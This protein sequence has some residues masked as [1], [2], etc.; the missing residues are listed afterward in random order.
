[1]GQRAGSA[2]ILATLASSLGFGIALLNGTKAYAAPSAPPQRIQANANLLP[3]GTSEN[4]ILTIHLEVREGEWF[5]EDE[6]GPSMKVF[7]LGEPGKPAQIPGPLIRVL[8]GTTIHASVHN[9]L[10][11]AV[12]MH[13]MHSR[14]GKTDDVIDI[15]AGE[16]WHASFSAGE[17]GAYY[18]WA[19]A[20]GDTYL[21]RPYKEDSQL[22]GAF[23]VDPAGTVEHDRIFVIGVWRD[24]QLP[25]KSFDIP[26]INGK[27][28]PYTERLEYTTGSDVRWRWINASGVVH[29]MHM[30]GSYF[31]VDAMGDGEHDVQFPEAQRR[32]VAT[33]LMPI[34]TTMTTYWQPNEPGRWIF[35]CHILGHISPDTMKLRSH[36][37]AEHQGMSHDD[38]L[39]DMAG[40]VVG[41]TVLPRAGD[42]SHPLP[43]KPRRTV[44]LVIDKQQ[45]GSTSRAGYALNEHDKQSVG[46]SAPGRTLVL[47]RG[48]PVA[49]RILNR[50]SEPT[51]VHWHGIELQ[52][53]YDGVAGWTGFQKQVTPMIQP[54]KSFTVYFNPP[55]AG[56]FIYH[57]HMN[58]ISQLSSGLYGA[59]VVLP[60]GDSFHPETDKIFLMSRNGMR[61]D[62]EFLLNGSNAPQPVQWHA[63]QQY[64][65][66]FIDINANNTVRIA[67]TQNGTPVSWT[68]FAKDGADLPPAQAMT[69]PA[70]LLIAPGETYDFQFR[71][72]EEGN[73]QLSL[74][75]VLLK[76]KLTQAISVGPSASK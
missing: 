44:D 4:G 34:G 38:P 63:G 42:H 72:E 19:T 47:T 26:V 31:R 75:I 39:H 52:S 67:L 16:T 17:P 6:H 30:H 56:T 25:Q 3:A 20:N 57:T 73:L 54:G 40:L 60:P 12:V 14:P 51:S 70:T 64:R 61:E 65:L 55:R 9:T 59:I 2:F 35:H 48:E 68:S 24:Q 15:P 76:E 46:V 32:L 69:R 8:T 37:S 23:I 21:G 53:Y 22:S 29:P 13:G 43:P 45:P 11:V 71:P 62:G 66:R 10:A 7:A 5:P 36:S 50:L 58:D 49:V 1:M 18:Y 27:S 28:W 41:I 33:Q 74:E